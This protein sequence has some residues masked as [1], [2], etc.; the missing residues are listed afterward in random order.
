MEDVV[1]TVALTPSLLRSGANFILDATLEDGLVSLHFDGL[2]RIPGPSDLG[3]FHYIPLLIYEAQKV[4]KEQRILLELYALLLARLQGRAP[5]TGIVWCGSDC[6]VTK[7]RLN[8]GVRK[9][10][11]LLA[12]VK[13]IHGAEAPPRLILNDH[14]RFCEF[15]QRCLHQAVQEDNI[16]LLRG[17]GEKEVRRYARKGILTVTQLAHTFRPRR[18][19]KRA[20]PRA[21]QHYHA[22]QALA[23]RDKKVY[24]FGTPQLPIS[25]VHIYLDVEGC[26][27]EGYDYLIG[28]IVAE[29][30]AEQRYSFWAD[31]RDQQD[32][33]CEQFLE[34]VARYDDILVFCYGSYEKAFLKRMRKRVKRKKEVDRVLKVMV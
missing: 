26:P 21:H 33:I 32:R 11:S 12:E 14:C 18:R 8:R 27:D 1:R 2:K 29:S 13:R 30:G 17:M 20:A 4:R 5:T 15:R 23:I 34:V 31:D 6:R 9:A 3:D 25:P 19:G 7:V 22:L 10:E 28:M 24:V 16:S